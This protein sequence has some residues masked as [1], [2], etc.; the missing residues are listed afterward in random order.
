MVAF[1]TFFIN[2][3][4]LVGW[5]FICLKF[6]SKLTASWHLYVWTSFFA[7]FS[8][9]DA[10]HWKLLELSKRLNRGMGSTE[11]NNVEAKQQIRTMKIHLQKIWYWAWI[12][13]SMLILSVGVFQFGKFSLW[14]IKCGAFGLSYG[15][16]LGFV[17][18]SVFLWV[19]YL[20]FDRLY[21][22]FEDQLERSAFRADALSRLAKGNK[23]SDG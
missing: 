21:D 8:F 16:V 6:D 9:L 1:L 5:I 13:K 11:R 23:S 20:V 3:T 14:Q 4:I 15:L 22:R 17:N 2:T 19:Y 10:F 12:F 7:T 18:M